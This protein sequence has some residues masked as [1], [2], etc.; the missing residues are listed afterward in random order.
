MAWSA[1]Q[2]ASGV[3][4]DHNEKQV[5][6]LSRAEN[7]ASNTPPLHQKKKRKEKKAACLML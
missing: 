2:V 1:E 6:N 3:R 5:F 7:Q 4:R